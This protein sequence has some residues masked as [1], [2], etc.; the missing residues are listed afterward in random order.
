MENL[1]KTIEKAKEVMINSNM[2]HVTIW[3]TKSRKTLIY[4]FNFEKREIGFTSKEYGVTRKVVGFYEN[5]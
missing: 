2:P 5:N 3:A 4:G 1:T